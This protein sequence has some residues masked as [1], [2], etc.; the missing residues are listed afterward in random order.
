MLARALAFSS[1]SFYAWIYCSKKF[2]ASFFETEA[3]IIGL[4]AGAGVGFAAGA[5]VGLAKGA[6]V[7]LATGGAVT[8]AGFAVCG[9][10][11]GVG[12]TDVAGYGATAFGTGAVVDVGVG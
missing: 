6:A 3:V 11:V 4:A 2:K 12:W 8:G 7:S 5:G 1:S 9:K 10:I